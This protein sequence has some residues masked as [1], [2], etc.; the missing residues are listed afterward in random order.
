MGNIDPY[1]LNQSRVNKREMNHAEVRLWWDL[2]GNQ[3]GV[4][5]RRQHVACGYLLDFACVPIKL[6]IETDGSHH[7][8][9][10]FDRNRD[11]LLQGHGWTILRF[12]SW[13]VFHQDQ[14]V[15]DTIS[16]TIERLQRKPE[17]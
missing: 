14:M 2:R 7:E 8:D 16:G 10:P 1:L 13:D 4:K 17:F 11:R 3:F 15:I 5:F 9:S 12:W 6:D